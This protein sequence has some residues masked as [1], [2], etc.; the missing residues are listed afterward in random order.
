MNPNLHRS[1]CEDLSPI[2][3]GEYVT[4]NYPAFGVLRMLVEK[5][6]IYFSR[7]NISQYREEDYVVENLEVSLVLKPRLSGSALLRTRERLWNVSPIRKEPRA[8]PPDPR[9]FKVYKPSHTSPAPRF[10]YDWSLE[11]LEEFEDAAAIGMFLENAEVGD[12]LPF[13]AGD[14]TLV[15]RRIS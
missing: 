3:P 2:K 14:S 7:G 8:T 9:R 1:R 10:G 12:E 6:D 11:V 5:V 15:V 4:V 13:T